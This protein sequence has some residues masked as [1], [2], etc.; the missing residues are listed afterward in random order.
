MRRATVARI[1]APA[2]R[3]N[4]MRVRELAPGARTM[5]CVKG[6]GYGHGLTDTAR[7]LADDV[8][9]FAV[10]TMDEGLALRAAGITGPVLLLEGPHAAGDVGEAASHDLTLC[11]HAA[12]QLDWLE[13][14]APARRPPCW[15]KIDTGMH[16]LGFAPAAAGQAFR[17]LTA[18]A[19]GVAPVLCTHFAT[20]NEPTGPGTDAQLR[21][22]D[23]AT[24]RLAGAHSCANS[25]AICSCPASHR[26]WVRPGYML[27]GG[28]PLD[29]RDA[30]ALDLRPAMEFSAE[31]IAIRTIAAGERVG[32][33]GRWRAARPSRI[34]T[35]AAGYGDGYPRHAPDGTPVRIG[36]RRSPLAGRVSMDMIT[37][38]VT[39]NPDAVVGARAVL[40]GSDPG[41]DEIAAAAGTIGYELLAG[42]P[43]RVAR[44]VEA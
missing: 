15:L 43:A 41:V 38:D 2:L 14:Q 21:C 37:V 25:A 17:R 35:V 36:A 33:G 10:A 11:V 9:G 16:R 42:L 28:S 5:A 27:Y 44:K 8:D 30:R 40:W 20:A 26:D 6:N 31:V 29:D 34:A 39:E 13:Q 12:H 22:F 3:H 32:Y 1:F 19:A 24:A 4:A 7:A 23:R 18:L